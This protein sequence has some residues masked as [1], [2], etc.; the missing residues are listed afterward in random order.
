[1]KARPIAYWTATAAIA[2]ETL[3]GGAMD[4]IHGR[5][6][7]VAGR[8]VADVVTPPSRV[9]GA[10]IPTTAADRPTPLRLAEAA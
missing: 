9:L 2:G 4:L 10:I 3:A 1:M 7:V 5:E 8:P 6:I